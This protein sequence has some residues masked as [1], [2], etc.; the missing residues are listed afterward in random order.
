MRGGTRLHKSHSLQMSNMIFVYPFP[1]SQSTA[2]SAAAVMSLSLLKICVRVGR[3]RVGFGRMRREMTS[4]GA[5][6]ATGQRGRSGG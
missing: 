3:S 2:L 5:T 6:I 4:I 1:T